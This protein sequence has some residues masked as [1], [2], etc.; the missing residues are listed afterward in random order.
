MYICGI[1]GKV[2]KPREKQQLRVMETRTRPTGGLEIVREAKV[3]H[4]CA[5]LAIEEEEVLRDVDRIDNLT[6]TL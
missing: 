5:E 3:C 2:S 6:S 1:C 4:K